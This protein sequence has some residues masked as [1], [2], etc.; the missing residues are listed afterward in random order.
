MTARMLEGEEPA[1]SAESALWAAFRCHGDRQAREALVLHHLGFARILA[2]KLFARRLAD[3]VV[4]DDFLQFA[5][6]GLMEAIDRFD[7]DA[8]A[9]F[10]TFAAHR[11]QGAILTGVESLTERQRQI[12][13]RRS[14]R[15]E[16]IQ[17]LADRGEDA[18]ADAF[19]RLASLAVGLALGFM[20]E[21]L[22][23]YQAEGGS[24]GDNSYAQIEARQTREQL[25]KA[26]ESLPE[27]EARIVRHHY[28]QQIP[29]DDIALTLGLTKGRVSQLH[30]RALRSLQQALRG[31]DELNLSG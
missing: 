15:R 27:R 25:L 18:Q 22:G 12:A 19:S 23:M 17:S 28:F 1:T 31:E 6:V 14:L 5:S 8:G 21:D 11:I 10:R 4:F 16:R 29:F 24:Y 26:I 7:L 30:R 3:D 20:L 9:S 13:L 2:A